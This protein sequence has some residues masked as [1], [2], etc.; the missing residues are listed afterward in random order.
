M[1]TRKKAPLGKNLNALLGKGH[2]AHMP[3]KKRSRPKTN[4]ASC[5]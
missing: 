5:R 2:A 4:C 3:A 1:A